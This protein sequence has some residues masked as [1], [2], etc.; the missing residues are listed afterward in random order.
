MIETEGKG[1]II[2]AEP[3]L[4]ALMKANL[5]QSTSTRAAVRLSPILQI[6][7]VNSNNLSIHLTNQTN[8]NCEHKRRV[9]MLL[10]TVLLEF[11]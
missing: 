7:Q 10:C 5:G 11:F 1:P 8:T 2:E 9:K 3:A 4:P 6:R